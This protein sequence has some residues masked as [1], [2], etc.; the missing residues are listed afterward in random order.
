M[1]GDPLEGTRLA[2]FAGD[3]R[4]GKRSSEA[5]TRADLDRIA[6][7]DGILGSYQHVA[8]E[9]AL[10]STTCWRPAPTLGR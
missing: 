7:L 8:A 6:R 9:S 2:G 3:L 1:S 4:A 10:R 5:I